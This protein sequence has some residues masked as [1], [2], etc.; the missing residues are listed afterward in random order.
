MSVSVLI[1]AFRPTFL[2]EAITSVLAQDYRDFELIVSDDSGA[3]EVLPVVERFADPRI[4][5]VRTAGRTG[6]EE[7]MRGLWVL[8]KHDLI[9]FLFD[10]DLLTPNALSD[11][12]GEVRAAPNVS[13]VFGRR[14]VIDAQG[15]V[16]EEPPPFSVE[17]G[18]LDR[19]ALA[20]RLVG[21]VI[22]PIGEFS[23]I[24]IN[25]AVGLTPADFMVYGGYD[26][27]VVTDVGF[28]L[29]AAARAPCAGLNRIVGAFR[30]HANQNSSPD[31]NPAFAIGICEWELFVRG[32]LSGGTLPR[33]EALAALARLA[34]AYEH[35]ARTLPAIAQMT[36]GLAD[37]RGRVEAGET[38]VLD[39]AFRERWNRFVGAVK[40]G[41]PAASA[42]GERAVAP[43]PDFP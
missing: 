22:N 4:R 17:R 39:Q 42:Q 24:L 38:D 41:G 30:R 13:F 8:A 26:I 10:D 1:P 25:R 23:N 14:R 35:W 18:Q 31:F 40:S 32:E 3:D 7:N 19:G 27:E 9:N 6:G 33:A 20:R 11:L 15:Q 29:N 28:F 5:Y 16:L 34:G 2:A 21:K 43:T 37:L 36:P 12:V